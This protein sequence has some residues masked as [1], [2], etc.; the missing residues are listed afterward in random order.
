MR[1]NPSLKRKAPKVNIT[2]SRKTAAIAGV[3]AV[4]G[5]LP[6]ESWME[7]QKTSSVL[8]SNSLWLVAITVFLFVPAYFFVIGRGSAPFSRTWF[9]DRAE[10]ARYGVIVGRMLVWFASAVVF[11]IIW[12]TLFSLVPKEFQPSFLKL[13]LARG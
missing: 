7:H 9:L 12:S 3:W 5:L 13:P 8:L 6:F 10:R 11:G 4:F 2:A 1:P